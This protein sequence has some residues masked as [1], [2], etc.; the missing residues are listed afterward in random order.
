MLF[1]RVIRCLEKNASLK[2]SFL[3]KNK[4]RIQTTEIFSGF[5]SRSHATASGTCWSTTSNGLPLNPQPTSRVFE[6]GLVLHLLGRALNNLL[7][8]NC[9]P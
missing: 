4:T 9:D 7:D 2:Q 3:R 5:K 6:Y 1:Q 8:E